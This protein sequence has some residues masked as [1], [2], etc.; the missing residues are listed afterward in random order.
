MQAG[1][2]L[3]E[4]YGNRNFSHMHR[5]KKTQRIANNILKQKYPLPHMVVAI[6]RCMIIEK[7]KCRDV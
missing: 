1:G 4:F 3:A 7:S 2:V 5:V 6:N